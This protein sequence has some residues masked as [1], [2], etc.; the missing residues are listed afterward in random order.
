MVRTFVAVAATLSALFYAVSPAMGAPA[1]FQDF[2][3]GNPSVKVYVEIKNSSGDEKVD[4]NMLK[5]LLEE[6][7]AA[8]KSHS[9]T[10]VPTAGE[11][12]LILRGDITEYVWMES[13]P[14]DQ[15][16]GLD[17]AAIDAAIV[18]N[19]ARIYV[20]SELV[21][22][23]N[24]KVLWSDKVMGTM[25]QK[26]MPKETSYDILYPRFVKSIMTELFKKRTTGRL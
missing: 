8:R 1:D 14:V 22:V 13:D 25:T 4:A 24:N 12:D 7:F 26:V 21:S 17:S 16:W 15:V 23:K 2:L 10:A 20:K 3:D 9:F 11:A 18:E 5:K 6:A 19:Y